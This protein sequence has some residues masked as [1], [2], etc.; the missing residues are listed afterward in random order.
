M[1]EVTVAQCQL[2]ELTLGCLAIG[3]RNVTIE[4]LCAWKAKLAAVINPRAPVKWSI[5]ILFPVRDPKSVTQ[6]VS[7]R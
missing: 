6:R 7:E 2:C 5:E 3:R 1:V 4:Q